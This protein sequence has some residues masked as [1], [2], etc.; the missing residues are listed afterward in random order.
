MDVSFATLSPGRELTPYVTR[1]HGARLGG[2]APQRQLELPVA[3]T[4]LIVTLE[5]R[6]RI[7]VDEQ[8]PLRDH[9]SFAGGLTLA[10]AV[11]EHGGAYDIVEAYLTPAG[12]TAVL[13][14]PAARLA[15]D[16]VALDALL[17]AEATLLAER[18]A[19][20]QGWRMRL[21]AFAAWL[22]ARTRRRPA[23]LSPDVS[24]AL[25]RLDATGGGVT[26]GTLQAELVCSRRHLATR[27]AQSVGTTPKAYAQLVRF[28]RAAERLRG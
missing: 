18:L 13:D 16:V 9:T 20:L 6:W 27:F 21:T 23:P 3:G 12:T 1:L 14:V 4:A 26:I 22:I 17:G 25:R 7:G 24:W 19:G 2:G 5:H 28:T 11:S 15:G 8:A 10:P